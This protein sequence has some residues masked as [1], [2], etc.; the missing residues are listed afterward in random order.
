MTCRMSGVPP[1]FEHMF[2]KRGVTGMTAG[3]ALELAIKLGVPPSLILD[4]LHRV[5]E[6]PT[7][8]DA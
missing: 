8:R 2:D 7:R 4:V 5:I 1:M 3:Q 6:K